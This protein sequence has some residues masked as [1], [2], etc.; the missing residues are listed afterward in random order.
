NI[1]GTV[2]PGTN[3][4]HTLTDHNVFTITSTQANDQHSLTQQYA[5]GGSHVMGDFTFSTDLSWTDSNFDFENP[6]LDTSTIVPLVN[7]STNEGGTAQLDYGGPGF[8][9]RNP[10]GFTLRNWFDNHGTASGSSLDWRGDVHWAPSTDGLIKEISG[11]V[12]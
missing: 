12:R 10:A 1:S 6:I 2:F 11:G 4:M 8:D 3:I 9:I 7:V 5:V